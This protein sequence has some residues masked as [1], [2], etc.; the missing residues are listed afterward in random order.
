MGHLA[1]ITRIVSDCL[2]QQ[3]PRYFKMPSTL[4]LLSNLIAASVDDIQAACDARGVPFPSLDEVFSQETE[5]IRNQPEVLKATGILVAAAT[6]LIAT[7]RATPTFIASASMQ[8]MITACLGVVND[9]HVAEILREAGPQG[10]HV[11]DI[12]KR[13]GMNASR[14]SRVLRLLATNHIFREITPDVFTNNRTSSLLDTN[15]AVDELL[16]NSLGKH[17]G[18]PGYAAFVGHQTDE[19]FKIASALSETLRDPVFGHSDE[20]TQC[21]LT[22]AM[23]STLP[24][25]EFLELPENAH[26]LRR[27]GVVMDASTKLQPAN[28][29][30]NGFDFTSLPDNSLV[31]DVAG[32]IGS[33]SLVLAKAYPR[34][35]FLVEDRP[36]TVVEGEKFWKANLPEA[37][38]TGR[39]KF[40]AHDIF[41]PQPDAYKNPA[42]FIL[43]SIL[44]DWS[45]AY[46][47]RI[48]KHLRSAAG[49]ET[50]LVVIDHVLPYSCPSDFGTEESVKG[51]NP[52]LPPAPLLANMGGAGSLQYSLDILMLSIQNGQERTSSHFV[53]LLKNTGWELKEIKRTDAIGSW[54]PH[55]ISTPI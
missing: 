46:A 10:L 35:N 7:A 15:K 33:V 25:F 21:A 22:K 52:P 45:D 49:P 29:I 55:L 50:K 6:Q 27:F 23:H 39:V 3:A 31:I 2:T 4:K 51:L 30:L 19:C 18:T 54:Y 1:Y 11:T 42:V 37:L 17:D 12:A 13:S 43:R 40:V 16:K 20:P 26:R 48:L 41:S 36:K 44:H 28:A 34:L 5:E 47:T 53:T 14:I 32:G 38:T 9:G 8:Y 24:A